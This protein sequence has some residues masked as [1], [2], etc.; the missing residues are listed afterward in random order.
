MDYEFLDITSDV[1]FRAYGANEAEL[2]INAGRA[3]FSVICEIE[4]VKPEKTVEITVSAEGVEELLFEWLS[5]L[6]TESEIEEIFFS[7]FLVDEIREKDGQHTLK[8]RALGEDASVEK[9]G[10][11]VKGVTYYSFK[12][13]E[14]EDMLVATVTLDI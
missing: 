8:G 3:M 2:F 9:G 13:E 10:T 4:S 14:K 6:L 7:E 5:R 11:L 12:I 1:M